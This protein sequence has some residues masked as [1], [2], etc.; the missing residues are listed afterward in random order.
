M[1][2]SNQFSKASNAE[3][4]LRVKHRIQALSQIKVYQ[5]NNKMVPKRSERDKYF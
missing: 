4:K 1:I 2:A 5:E 3:L